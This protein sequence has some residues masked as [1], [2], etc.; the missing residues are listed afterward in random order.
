ML[1][2]T[3]L[4]AR[5]KATPARLLVSVSCCC[6]WKYCSYLSVLCRIYTAEHGSDIMQWYAA[7]VC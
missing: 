7:M 1:L 5:I 3:V 4:L 6:F 2:Q